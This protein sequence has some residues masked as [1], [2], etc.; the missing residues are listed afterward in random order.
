VSFEANDEILKDFLESSQDILQQLD[1]QLVELEQRPDDRELLNAVFR[2]FHTIKGGAGFLNLEALVQIC[3]RAEDL[4]NLLRRGERQMSAP[5][6]DAVLRALDAIKKIFQQL[7]AG[8]PPPVADPAV[9]APLERC[10]QAPEA[11]PAQAA[12]I[13]QVDA[14]DAVLAALRQDLGA[15]PP[16]GAGPSAAGAG[17]DVISEAE[18]EALLDSL[19]GKPQAAAATATPA[20]QN[21][22]LPPAE[23]VLTPA[24]SPME[25]AVR[26]DT[27]RL[28]DM[29]NLVGELVLVRNRLVNLH[30][31]SKD[32][33]T[34]KA[35]ADLSRV[36]ADLQTVVMKTRLQPIRQ[37]YGKFPRVVRDLA[38][39]LNKEVALVLRGEETEVDKNL[40]EALYD[41]L[42]HLVRN[43]VD[44]GIEPP[45]R[46]LAAGKPR[47]G[48]VELTAE[49]EGDHI[50][51]TVSD[52]GA[53]L[54]VEAL[55]R[56]AVERGLYDADSV[57]RLSEQECYQ[58]IFLP[59][60][61]TKEKITDIS[62]RGVGMDVVRTRIAEIGGAIEIDSQP[63]QG[64]RLR[65]RVPLTL[66]ILPTLMV[67]V[68]GRTFAL[69]LA[70]V[71]EIQD[72]DLSRT[73]V[74]DGRR[75]VLLRDQATPIFSLRQWL[76]GGEPLSWSGA[77]SVVIV[78]TGRER[79]G[80]VVDRLL[81][82]EEV[83][84]KPLG[85]CA[86][87]TP[88]LAG[89]TITGDGRIALILDVPA[90]VKHHAQ[91]ESRE[92]A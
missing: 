43:A 58:L 87:G 79:V 41:P 78:E 46:R 67:V 52:D 34:A 84:V 72:M 57:A 25:T 82:Q 63:G 45:E 14:A 55:R 53:G 26:V 80:L 38:R 75:V 70:T 92:V 74:L 71:S 21:P 3:H 39:R 23:G 86:Q 56:K 7:H 60:F 40:V 36:T 31:A 19:H 17:H 13:P 2:G 1:A 44:H 66:A 16:A 30:V 27:H 5:L 76:F 69:P 28:D 83:V 88:G 89:A 62:G 35:I 15:A 47:Q 51:L 61:S 68:G 73:R 85:A 29:M 4:F 54:D 77:G 32:E 10:L 81:G 33:K 50:L 91:R 6:M 18:F 65:I 22:V 59:G 90:L 48:K 12:P 11:P 42:V 8:A 20:A 64:S 49:Q 37:V 9:L 24:A